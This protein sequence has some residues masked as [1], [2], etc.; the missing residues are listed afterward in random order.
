M[1]LGEGGGIAV[2]FAV[3]DEVDLALAIQGDVLERWRATAVKPISSSTAAMPAGSAAVY[4][5]NSK[6]SVPMGLSNR[7]PLVLWVLPGLLVAAA[8]ANWLSAWF[9]WCLLV[10]EG[11]QVRPMRGVYCVKT[12]ICDCFLRDILDN[13]HK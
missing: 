8:V 12:A 2:W 11:R 7:S 13:M 1:H 10:W 9:I 4:S 5:T 3:E 6:P